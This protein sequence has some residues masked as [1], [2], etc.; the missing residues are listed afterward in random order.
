MELSTVQETAQIL[1]V[2]PLTIRRYI[3]EGRLPAVRVGKRVRVR[4]EALDQFLAPVAAKPARRASSA[5]RGRPTSAEDPLWNIVGI[6]RS[7][8]PGDVSESKHK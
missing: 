7:V 6:A 8:G 1:K 3:A 5:A 2:A 4:K